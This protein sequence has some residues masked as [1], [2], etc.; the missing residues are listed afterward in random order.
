MVGGPGLL[1]Q[2]LLQ[3][4]EHTGDYGMP[5]PHK[6]ASHLTSCWC[7]SRREQSNISSWPAG[8]INDCPREGMTGGT[9][10]ADGFMARWAVLIR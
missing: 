3:L 9:A 1:L 5:N 8:G 2:V 6:P 7:K 10:A 4:G